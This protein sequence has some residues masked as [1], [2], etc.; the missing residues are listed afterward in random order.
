M[1]EGPILDLGV[2]FDP[3]KIQAQMEVISDWGNRSLAAGTY[4]LFCIEGQVDVAGVSLKEKE[5]LRIEIKQPLSLQV[6][7]DRPENTVLISL[8]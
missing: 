3:T 6:K 5:S 2:I 8:V 4:C 7:S 1:L